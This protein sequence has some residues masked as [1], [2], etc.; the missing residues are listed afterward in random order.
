MSM[1]MLDIL[2]G[3]V[4]RRESPLEEVKVVVKEA[5]PWASSLGVMR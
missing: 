5:S 3:I 1:V 2:N 4:P